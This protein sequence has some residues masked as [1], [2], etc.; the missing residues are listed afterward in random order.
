M[1]MEA[2]TS[3]T[4]AHINVIRKTGFKNILMAF[5][6]RERIL[7]VI[8]VIS[9][10]VGEEVEHCVGNANYTPRFKYKYY[11]FLK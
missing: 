7:N 11:T 5:M 1:A 8:N 2:Y 10:Q 3:A 6:E 9:L 4:S